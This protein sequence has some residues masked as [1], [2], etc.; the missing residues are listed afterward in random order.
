MNTDDLA[1]SPS[2]QDLPGVLT[3]QELADFLKV[4]IERLKRWSY[5]G[6]GPQTFKAGKL[7]LI[8]REALLDWFRSRER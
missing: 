1:S 4:P 3:E 5:E 2:L 7:R 6:R 8:R